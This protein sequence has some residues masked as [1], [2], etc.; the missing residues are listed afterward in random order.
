MCVNETATRTDTTHD[1]TNVNID[2]LH[3]AR[4]YRQEVFGRSQWLAAVGKLFVA[5]LAPHDG[6]TNEMRPASS[7]NL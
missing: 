3:A 7:H 6:A 1:S 2:V 5:H 4:R